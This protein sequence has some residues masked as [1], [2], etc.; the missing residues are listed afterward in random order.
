[1]IRTTVIASVLLA[2]C[3]AAN[4]GKL[5]GAHLEGIVPR[6][7]LAF[8]GEIKAIDNSHRSIRRFQVA[9]TE[10]LIGQWRRR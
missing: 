9:P 10:A 2:L 4:A 1:M 6:V 7:K 5:V 3:V 8:V